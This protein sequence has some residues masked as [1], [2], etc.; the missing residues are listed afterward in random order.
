MIALL[1]AALVGVV[2]VPSAADVQRANVAAYV[3]AYER[4]VTAS[5]NSYDAAFT[6]DS[7]YAGTAEAV[8]IS[9]RAQTA[10]SL[11]RVAA[12]R[13]PALRSPQSL[14][15][16]DRAAFDQYTR[17]KAAV[18]RHRCDSLASLVAYVDDPSKSSAQASVE[19]SDAAA[20]RM[21]VRGK[22]TILPT[23]KRLHMRYPAHW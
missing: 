20:E 6:Y 14:P 3:T 15:A 7:F 18:Y 12:K 23:F 2:G 1:V 11:C 13:I 9:R 8:A 10:L 19:R 21:Y 17:I 4:T 5:V 16:D 22:A